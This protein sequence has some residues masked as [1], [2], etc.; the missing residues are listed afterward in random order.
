MAKLRYTDLA[1][2]LIINYNIALCQCYTPCSALHNETQQKTNVTQ[3][4]FQHKY[5]IKIMHKKSNDAL[6]N[7][8]G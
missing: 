1:M 4:P 2:Y 5:K 8:E 7:R 3:Q 6:M